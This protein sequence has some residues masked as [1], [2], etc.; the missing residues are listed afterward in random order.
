ML[1]FSNLN[2]QK[3]LKLVSEESSSKFVNCTTI[4]DNFLE[5]INEIFKIFNCENA[6]KFDELWL[7]F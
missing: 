1:V 4:V 3:M 7:K 5:N 6:K 2:F